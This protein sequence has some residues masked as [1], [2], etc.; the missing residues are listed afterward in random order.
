MQGS[1]VYTGEETKDSAMQGSIMYTRGGEYLEM[2]AI[3]V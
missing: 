2:A 3:G 1:V